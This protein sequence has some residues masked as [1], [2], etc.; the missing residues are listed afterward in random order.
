MSIWMLLWA[1]GEADKDTGSIPQNVAP[2]IEWLPPSERIVDGDSLTL[3]VQIS[4]EDGISAA[5]VYYRS[6]GGAYW[7][8][9][10]L[11]DSGD[12][13]TTVIP[14]V[15]VP[16][17]EIYFKAEDL[18][19]PIATTLLPSNGP[20]QPYVVEVA[21][22]SLS[23]PFSE[24]FDLEEGQLTL[25]DR[26]WWT[27]SETRNTYA[28]MLNGSRTHTGTHAVNHLRG[29]DGMPE[30][31]D[32]L[33]SPPLDF[34]TET[35]VMVGW[36]EY[37]LA[38]D[39]MVEHSLW[40]STGSRLPDDGDFQQVE[41][42]DAPTSGAWGQHRYVDLSQFAG[43]SQVYIGWRWVGSNADE[44]SIDDITVRPLAPDFVIDVISNT[45]SPLQPG[46]LADISV[47]IEN[48]TAGESATCDTTVSV[49]FGATPNE[50]TEDGWA[51]EGEETIFQE[52]AF[53]L[54]SSLNPH[55]NLPIN[56]E[57]V[58]GDDVWVHEGS[59]QIGQPSLAQL[60]LELPEM[61]QVLGTVGIGDPDSPTWSTPIVSAVLDAGVHEFTLDVTDQFLHLPPV[62]GSERWFLHVDASVITTIQSFQIGY[63]STVTSAVTPNLAM[64]DFPQTLLVPEPPEF[65]VT[66]V[67]PNTVAPGD[68]QIPVTVTLSNVGEASQGSVVASVLTQDPNVTVDSAQVGLVDADT[69]Y[70][71]EAHSI[72]T[73][74]S[75]NSSHTSSTPIELLVLLADGVESWT[76]PVEIDVPF[77]RLGVTG[78]L[79][80]DSSGNNDGRLDPN[81]S[82]QLEISIVN[83]GG[84]NPTGVVT[85]EMSILSTSTATAT[86]TNDSPSFGFVNAGSI[87]DDDDFFVSITS[88]NA[89]DTLD[90]LLVMEDN[91]RT[92]E[93]T[94]SI[95]LGEVPWIGV[96]PLQDDPEDSLDEA[97]FD[98]VS[99]EYRVDGTQVELKLE[100]STI[101]NPSTAFI[102]AWGQSGGAGYAYFRWVVQSGVGTLQGY[103]SGVG[104]QPL[105]TLAVSYPDDHHVIMSFD[106]SDLDLATEQFDIGFAAGW[107]GP[108]TYYCDQF[109]DNWG[110]PYVSFSTGQW[111][112]VEW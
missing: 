9:T 57:V 21:P 59:I 32:W 30:L 97:A 12:G 36:W 110:Y 39:S 94:F 10:S 90:C 88:G 81:E 52:F 43:E 100:S 83:S 60:T 16:G 56:V 87:K 27:P 73:V 111:F 102:E 108:P 76:I 54:D 26:D 62:A 3:S 13:W 33:I 53:I 24:S 38:V 93:D 44:W 18:G 7:E 91:V 89:G 41:I 67:T 47:I 5:S 55:R 95:V 45:T 104:F 106:S 34:S 72:E 75:I 92:Y 109:P 25:L 8:S 28:W 37:G 11:E 15:N 46:D 20:S 51:I 64:P 80:D 31:R 103:I 68:T 66:S 69:W 70:R 6:I 77:P 85:G 61:G 82:A 29:S 79:I 50:L 49:P 71:S 48:Q 99:A 2:V 86:V 105:G 96:S 35:G 112:T 74:I 65:L 1:C 17:L 98:I 19:E 22:E 84:L 107:C 14:T 42:L 23:I 40:V 58:C 63:G 4:D 78:V 101:V